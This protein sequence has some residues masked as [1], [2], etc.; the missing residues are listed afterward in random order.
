MSHFLGKASG[1]SGTGISL[2]VSGGMFRQAEFLA[3]KK[4]LGAWQRASSEHKE[5]KMELKDTQRTVQA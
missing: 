3:A 5:S 4:I 1:A 2:C